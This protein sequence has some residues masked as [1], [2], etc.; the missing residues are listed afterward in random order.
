M[1]RSNL[2]SPGTDLRS[3]AAGMTHSRWT[4]TLPHHVHRVIEQTNHRHTPLG[5]TSRGRGWISLN[6]LTNK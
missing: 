6:K 2:I 5:R 4:Q 1:R 3:N